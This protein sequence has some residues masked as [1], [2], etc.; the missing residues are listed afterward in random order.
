MA[1]R[2][3]KIVKTMSLT[4]DNLLGIRTI[5]RDEVRP[6]VV[7]VVREEVRSIVREVVREEVRPI[8]REVV[9]D[10]VRP[11]VREEV[12][13]VVDSG[14]KELSGKVEALENDVKEIY[15]MLY[16]KSSYSK[17]S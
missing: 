6:I 3:S 12:K 4:A 10:D 2:Q 11:I 14:L 17:L 13:L 8:V 1:E 16:P 5:V 15:F 7:E 9:R